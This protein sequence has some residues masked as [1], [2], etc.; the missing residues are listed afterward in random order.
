MRMRWSGYRSPQPGFSHISLA[1]HACLAVAPSQR[2]P[3]LP[4]TAVIG[5]QHRHFVTAIPVPSSLAPCTGS[6]LDSTTRASIYGSHKTPSR[7]RQ[8]A[9]RAWTSRLYDNAAVIAKA[10][11][12]ALCPPFN[13]CTSATRSVDKLTGNGCR[14]APYIAR[15]INNPRDS[16]RRYG[17]LIG[18]VAGCATDLKLLL[19]VGTVVLRVILGQ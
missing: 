15:A 1:R 12:P 14:H 3:Q 7:H 11:V 9:R 17:G 16:L 19:V 8:L 2:Y 5:H 18:R 4:L 6:R 13:L 10:T